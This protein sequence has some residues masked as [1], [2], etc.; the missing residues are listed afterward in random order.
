MRRVALLY[1]FVHLGRIW[2]SIRDL[3][4]YLLLHPTCYKSHSRKPWKNSTC[5]LQ[6]T[7]V[8]KANLILLLCEK[9]LTLRTPKKGLR[10]PLES[11][12]WIITWDSLSM[13]PIFT[14]VMVIDV[15]GES[16]DRKVRAVC[17]VL[18]I[19]LVLCR[20]PLKSACL[21]KSGTRF[22]L[23]CCEPGLPWSSSS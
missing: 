8:K 6:K 13:F 12:D 15:D 14:M 5:S 20:Y 10:D 3:E 4:P 18:L 17:E 11:S 23:K 1:I 2:L 16:Q 21:W 9:V 22:G 19:K 7:R